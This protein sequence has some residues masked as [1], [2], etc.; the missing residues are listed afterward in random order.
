MTKTIIFFVQAKR[1]FETYLTQDSFIV[2][3]EVN[4]CVISEES[5]SSSISILLFKELPLFGLDFF[6][7]PKYPHIHKFK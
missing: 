4:S 6:L 5:N 3:K 7:I 1:K 2:T